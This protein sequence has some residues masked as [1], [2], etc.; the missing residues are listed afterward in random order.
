MPPIRHI[1]PHEQGAIGNTGDAFKSLERVKQ[2]RVASQFKSGKPV[3]HP[4]VLHNT[5]AGA[6][7]LLAGNTRLAYNAQVNKRSTPA[8][9]IPYH[10]KQHST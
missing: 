1:A 9:H 8:I 3:S 4:I 7:H 10:P 6:R 2:Q 5:A